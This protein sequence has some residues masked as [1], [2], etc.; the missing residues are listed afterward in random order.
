M[1]SNAKKILIL[2]DSTIDNRVWLGKEKY[3]LFANSMLSSF[4]PIVSGVINFIDFF[5]PFKSKSVVEN[6]SAQLPDIDIVDRT[7]D[8]FTTQSILNGDYKDKVFGRGIHR[9]FPHEMFKP[10]ETPELENADHIILSIGGNNLREFMLNALNSG[11]KEQRKEYIKNE[12]PKVF[13]KM[14]LDYQNILKEIT[15]RN[16]QAKIIL[17]TQYYPAINQKML[18]NRN[19]Y[20][21]MSE[22]G[23]AL[24]KGRAQDTIVEVMKDA[25]NGILKFIS[26]DESMRKRNICVVDVTSSLNPHFSENYEGQIEPSNMGGRQIAKM[27]AHVVK[28]EKAKGKRIYR[29]LPDY[30]SSSGANTDDVTTCDITSKTT[31]TPV[32]PDAMSKNQE[33]SWER[34]GVILAGITLFALTAHF[35]GAGFLLAAGAGMLGGMAGNNL[36]DRYGIGYQVK[37]SQQANAAYRFEA[38]ACD[39]AKAP[40]EEVNTIQSARGWLP[41]LKSNL[42]LSDACRYED[43]NHDVTNAMQSRRKKML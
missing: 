36:A 39:K 26:T 16:P 35:F 18:I 42:S 2:G 25:Y 41:Y 17:M 38:L 37:S 9:F 7:N 43:F 40:V 1:P 28:D 31:F 13:N 34:H 30:F 11:N 32:H 4:A 24:G 22:M 8:G 14:Q 5:N 29:F 33:Y 23:E 27:L 10:M 21:F 6:L 12:Y 19:I 20:D 15:R 3:H